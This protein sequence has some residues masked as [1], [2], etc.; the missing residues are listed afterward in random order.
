VV[1]PQG[2]RG[3]FRVKPLTDHIRTLLNARRVWIENAEVQVENSRLHG[4]VPVMKLA[5]IDDMDAAEALRGKELLLPREELRPLAK[6][7]YFLHDLVGLDVEGP[8]GEPLGRV[9]SVMET[10]GRPNLEVEGPRGE[11]LVPF[12]PEA[13]GEVDL[14]GGKLH[15][16][17][18]PGLLE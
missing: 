5:G 15:V 13:V 18:L 10:G 1:R 12:I 17:P 8:G 11:I 3:E 6:D 4:T 9:T 2:H 7:E 16:L 14:A